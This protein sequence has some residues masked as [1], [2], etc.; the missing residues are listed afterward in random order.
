[1]ACGISLTRD[2]PSRDQ[3]Q[4]PCSGSMEFSNYWTTRKFPKIFKPISPPL[5]LLKELLVNSSLFFKWPKVL[6]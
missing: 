3:T 4:D 1:M 6:K 2:P 5:Q